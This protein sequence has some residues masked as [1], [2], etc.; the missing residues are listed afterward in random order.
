MNKTLSDIA[1]IKAG[2]PFRGKIPEYKDGNAYTVQIKD[3]DNDG[4]IHWQQ[5]LRTNITGRKQPNWLQK[6]DVLFA[7][8]GAR[9][10]A[11]YVGS[12]DKQIVCA[13]HYYLIQVT[14][15]SVLPEFVAWQ[16]NQ[17]KAQRHF[18]SSAEGSAQMSI[19][20]A[21][22]E[23]TVIV[24]PSIE[25]QHA[26]VNFDNKV[27]NEKHLLTALIENREKQMQGIAKNILG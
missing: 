8:R 19:R 10:K 14:D 3:I 21:V 17:R 20:R 13:P 26:I 25:K 16:L 12:I 6:G 24:I 22:L 9:N 1:I 5:L 15:K 23:E 7:A 18:E 4:Y 27:K 11:A 2:H